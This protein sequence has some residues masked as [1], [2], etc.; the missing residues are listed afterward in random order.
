MGMAKGNP[1]TTQDAATC[2]SHRLHMHEVAK[3][4]DGHFLNFFMHY[5]T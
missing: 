1:F 4:H 3:G 2:Q 5:V